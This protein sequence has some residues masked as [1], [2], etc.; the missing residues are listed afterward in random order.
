MAAGE[1]LFPRNVKLIGLAQGRGRPLN[2]N[3]FHCCCCVFVFFLIPQRFILCIAF[4]LH[5]HFDVQFSFL[6]DFGREPF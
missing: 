6:V 4:I 2:S 3:I 5:S 1:V